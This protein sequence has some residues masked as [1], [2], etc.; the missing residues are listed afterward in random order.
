MFHLVLER[1]PAAAAL[2][3]LVGV[4]YLAAGWRKELEE[5]LEI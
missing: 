2:R 1:D 3:R 4:P 5:R